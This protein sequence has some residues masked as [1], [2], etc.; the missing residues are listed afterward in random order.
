MW[1]KKY[2]IGWIA[3]L[4]LTV[5][6][7]ST[8]ADVSEPFY[9]SLFGNMERHGILVFPK[10]RMFPDLKAFIDSQGFEPLETGLAVMRYGSKEENATYM[11]PPE[12]QDKHQ[13]KRFI[14]IQVLSNGSSLMVGIYD[15]KHGLTLPSAIF[16]LEAVKK[17]IP[18]T[19]EAFRKESGEKAL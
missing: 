12:I 7:S 3:A 18:K 6:A 4:C 19:L 15:P 14:V 9:Y 5:A 16:D 8:Q 2:L 13:M 10:A 17:N 1:P 11:M